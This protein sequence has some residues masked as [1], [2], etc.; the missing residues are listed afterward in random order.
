MLADSCTVAFVMAE[1]TLYFKRIASALTVT[2]AALS[3]AVGCQSTETKTFR[4]RNNPLT[5]TADD[6]RTGWYPNQP[7]LDPVL[8]AG[9]GLGR[10][11]QTTLPFSPGE[12]IYA[13][14][15]VKGSTVLIVTEANSVYALEAQTG[16]IKAQRSLGTAFRAAD[17]GA[18]DLVPTIG[19]T[20]TPVIDDATNT[21]YFFNKQ[22]LQDLPMTDPSNVAWFAHAVDVDT[23]VE[24]AGFPVT[25]A[26]AAANDPSAAFTP[27]TPH[28]R[29]A[30]L[31]MDGVG[32]G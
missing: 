2:I 19:I 16:A 1:M 5:S 7:A 17:I 4:D 13:Q 28:Q 8:V 24:R 12:Q 25:I 9:P 10:L 30:L 29:T 21:A 22:Y 20:G 31:L 23:L 6:L 26:G 11:W 14:P 3:T 18:T 27:F 15:L 32:D